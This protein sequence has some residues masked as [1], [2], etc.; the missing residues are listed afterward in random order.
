VRVEGPDARASATVEGPDAAGADLRRENA[1]LRAR[2]RS[3]EAEH[4]RYRDLYQLAPDAYLVTDVEGA[5]QEV[6]RAAAA[7]LGAPPATLVATT[8]HG[9]VA[10]EDRAAFQARLECLRAEGASLA[11]TARIQPAAG[12]PFATTLV[13]APLAPGPS[14]PPAAPIAWILRELPD[15]R[16][17]AGA[18]SPEETRERAAGERAAVSRERVRVA[19]ELHDALSQVLFSVALKLDWCL[20]RLPESSELRPKLE[21]IRHESGL[22]MA[23]IR[24][25]IARLADS[26]GGQTFSG[27][28]RTLVAQLR[29]LTGIVADL[30]EVGDVARLGPAQQ[31]VLGNTFQEALANVAKHAHASWAGIRLAVGEE[32]VEFE[33]ADDGVGVPADTDVA[34]LPSAPGHFG[35]RQMLERIEALGGRLELGRRGPSGFRLCGSLPLR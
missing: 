24:A 17:A 21:E 6:N 22:M 16:P 3:L 31:E 27:R 29:E 20:H 13:A 34:S 25:L 35:L 12:A 11:W 1:E 33:V 8:L 30:A 2:L 9:F 32:H 10:A 14:G 4:R 23:H 5:I 15:S 28:V 19:S 18:A 7:L 26:S